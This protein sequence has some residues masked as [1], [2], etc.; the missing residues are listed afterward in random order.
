MKWPFHS[1]RRYAADLSLMA[2]DVLAEE[3]RA[4][5]MEHLKRCPACRTRLAKLKILSDQL[6]SDGLNLPQI[7]PPPTLRRRWMS[8]VRKPTQ[9]TG[10]HETRPLPAWFSGQRLAWGAITAMW[11]LT[12]FFRFSAPTAPRPAV[13][14]TALPSLRQLLLAL[15]TEPPFNELTAPQNKSPVPDNSRHGGRSGKHSNK[16]QNLL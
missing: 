5:L 15:K 13:I 4:K 9:T 14:T 7:E 16:N 8:E 6:S 10:Q 2:A 11:M 3:T 1:C 12:L